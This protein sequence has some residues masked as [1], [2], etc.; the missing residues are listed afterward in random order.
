MPEVISRLNQRLCQACKTVQIVSC[1]RCARNE[2]GQSK[3]YQLIGR[4]MIA[5]LSNNAG[6]EDLLKTM[7]EDN[8]PV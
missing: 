1:V 4:R 7:S 3:D 8:L 6:N 5:R 2:D